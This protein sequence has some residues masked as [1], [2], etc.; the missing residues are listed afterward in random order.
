MTKLKIIGFIG[1]FYLI[2]VILYNFVNPF[3]KL[4]PDL[5]FFSTVLCWFFNPLGM[6]FAADLGRMI[7]ANAGDATNLV[8]WLSGGA[9]Q[10][11]AILFAGGILAFVWCLIV[12][13]ISWLFKRF[14]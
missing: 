1:I 7:M 4:L 2:L 8:N 14:G 5:G 6:L 12:A 10:N 3:L 11:T 9:V 13:F